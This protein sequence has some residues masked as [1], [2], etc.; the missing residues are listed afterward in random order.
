M[1]QEIEELLAVPEYSARTQ[2]V[3]IAVKRESDTRI[4]CDHLLRFVAETAA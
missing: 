4:A 1:T 2:A 3:R